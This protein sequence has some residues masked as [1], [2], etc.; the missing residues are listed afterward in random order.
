MLN[1][2]YFINKFPDLELFYDKIIHRKIHTDLYL[3]IPQGNK[4]F[5]WFT[6]YN[7]INLCVI[8]HINKYNKII[9]VEETN[10]SYDKSL[11][12]G[13]IIS[14]TYFTNNNIRYITCENVYFYKGKKIMGESYNNQLEIF[15]NIFDKEVRQVLYTKKFVILG[16]PIICDNYETAL[17]TSKQ[18]PY[19]VKGILFQN[20]KQNKG[21]G[22]ILN[23][24]EKI[25]ECVFKVTADIKED[26]YEL[27]CKDLN[28]NNKEFYNNALI[29]DYKTSVMMNKMFRKIKENRNLDLLEESDDEEE[30]ENID[31]DKFVN[32]KKTVYMKCVYV[33]KFKKWKPIEITTYGDK[34]IIKRE[35]QLLE[36][37]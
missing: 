5:L 37:L 15:K 14:G 26:I 16:L 24:E 22:L 29:P 34:L 6:Y 27:Y 30:F 12:Y 17:Q 13:T 36:Q 21:S 9:K 33:K 20:Y 35:V 7:N 2:K 32:L 3:L 10:L 23:K 19:R 4:V 8:L 28:E 11:S 31:E 25:I 1:H 18:V